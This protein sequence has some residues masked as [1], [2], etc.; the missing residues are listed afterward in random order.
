MNSNWFEVVVTRFILGWTITAVVFLL[1]MTVFT[2][3][4]LW[5]VVDWARNHIAAYKR[6]HKRAV[7]RR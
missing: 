7:H 2:C 1:A 4:G 5:E 6:L 3:L